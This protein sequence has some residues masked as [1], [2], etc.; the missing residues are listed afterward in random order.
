MVGAAE[1]ADP[2]SAMKWLVTGA[3]GQLGADLLRRIPAG[4]AV[5]L[6]RQQLDI[7]D[8]AAV[9]AALEQIRPDVIVNA[10]VYSAVDQAESDEASA[11]AANAT[12]PKNLATAAGAVGARLI[13]IS[14]DYVFAGDAVTP[15]PVDAPT[16]PK[17]VYGRTKQAGEQFV[18]EI[19]P[20]ASWVVRTAWLYGATG[21][22][23]VKTMIRL[24]GSRETVS[25]VDDQRGSPTW[26]ADLAA[27]LI[28]LAGSETA[29]GILHCTNSGDT[30][31]W[32]LACAVFKELGA[33]PDRVRPTT[34]AEYVFPTP[35][36]AYSV[37]S[38]SEWLAA[39]LPPMRDW[40]SALHA[41]FV[42]VGDA[43]RG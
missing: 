36:P 5:G 21:K 26:S 14:T 31:W 38:G 34:S 11:Y 1:E 24:E 42:E 35:R 17:T 18:R 32:G 3:G 4:E 15:Y 6:T 22:N 43:L 8:A 27:G 39:G 25:V 19:L 20:E 41:A 2:G 12:G 16:A 9:S 29:P 40:R 23:F 37:L 13:H 33:D 10:A 7:A 28:S 30:T